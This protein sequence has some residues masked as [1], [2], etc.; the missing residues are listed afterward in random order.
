MHRLFTVIGKSATGKDTIFK[1]LTES[2]MPSLITVVPYTTRPIRENETDGNEYF[3]VD[4]RRLEELGRAGKVI[5]CRTYATVHGEWSYFTVD[6]GQIDLE[7]NS[8]LMI[9]TPEGC[10][11]LREYFGAERITPVYIET[12]DGIRLQRAL[13]RERNEK[14]PRYAEMCRRFLADEAD[15][16]E[17]RLKEL[18][19]VKKYENMDLA[20]CLQEIID[21][22]LELL[23][24]NKD[25]GRTA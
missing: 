14:S 24:Y 21:D 19:I 12:E 3:F 4:K 20:K 11:K 15:F 16:S 2:G 8:Y 22:I 18:D 1:K 23:C 5:E 9:T 7:K 10:H 13:E 6:D 25:S 17:E